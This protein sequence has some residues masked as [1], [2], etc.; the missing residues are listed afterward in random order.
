MFRFCWRQRCPSTARSLRR[1]RFALPSRPL[2]FCR[3]RWH[4][5]SAAFWFRNWKIYLC[6][7]ISI[8]NKKS[9]NKCST[10]VLRPGFKIRGA[11][12]E[13]S[14]PLH[15]FFILRSTPP[16]QVI[17]WTQNGSQL[18]NCQKRCL[19]TLLG[20]REQYVS[21]KSHFEHIFAKKKN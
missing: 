14:G 1:R 2:R 20:M 13:R 12:S 5:W 6:S 4:T 15:L 3:P 21:V 8:F 11:G 7:I 16:L 10:N 19:S 18:Q 17:F 9:F